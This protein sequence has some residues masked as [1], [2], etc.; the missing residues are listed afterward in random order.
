M[1]N[2]IVLVLMYIIQNWFYVEFMKDVL[3]SSMINY[4]DFKV[5]VWQIRPN[6]L[7]GAR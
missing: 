2:Q 7:P 3:I 1:L 4:N 6:S 5:D